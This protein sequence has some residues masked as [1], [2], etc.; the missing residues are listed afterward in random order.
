MES[1]NEVYP[2]SIALIALKYQFNEEPSDA[3]L[4]SVLNALRG[5]GYIDGTRVLH[6]KPRLN[7]LERITL[8]TEGR[9]HLADEMKKKSKSRQSYSGN[10]A[11]NFI[12]T[13]LLSEFRERHLT[14]ADLQK[15]RQEQH[16]LPIYD[17]PDGWM[18]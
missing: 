12:L 10:E 8:T 15:M 5:D 16:Q 2:E 18:R 13:K 14:V 6:G 3:D 1:L 11:K 7:P 4:F 17:G 9:R